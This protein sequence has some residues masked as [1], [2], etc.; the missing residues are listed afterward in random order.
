MSIEGH[1]FYPIH[2]FHRQ[3]A[4]CSAAVMRRLPK[5]TRRCQNSQES[6]ANKLLRNAQRQGELKF[7]SLL[8]NKSVKDSFE[9]T[10]SLSEHTGFS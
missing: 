7:T 9:I 5:Q 2:L 10:E 1:K 4:T 6:V 3:Q 8:V